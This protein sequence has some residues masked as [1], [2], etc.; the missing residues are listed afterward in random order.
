MALFRTEA[1]LDEKSGLYYLEIYQPA[2]SDVPF[3]T[4]EPR[5]KTQAG[6]ENDA[7]AILAAGFNRVKDTSARSENS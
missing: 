6:A 1:R 3:V 2:D 5:Y 4:T 7:I